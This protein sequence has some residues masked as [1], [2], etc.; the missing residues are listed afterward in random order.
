MFKLLGL[1]KVDSKRCPIDKIDTDFRKGKT[2]D[3]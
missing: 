3:V 1:V 2:W